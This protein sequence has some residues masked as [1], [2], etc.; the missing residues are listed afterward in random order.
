MNVE[1]AGTLLSRTVFIVN[2]LAKFGRIA[3]SV[4]RNAHPIDEIVKF[5]IA[6]GGK[7]CVEQSGLLR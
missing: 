1:H 5:R 3:A 7:T 2:S 4:G 6:S